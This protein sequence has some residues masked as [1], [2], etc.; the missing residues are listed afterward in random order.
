MEWVVLGYTLSLAVFIPTSGWLGDRFG[1]E[2]HLPVRADPRSRSVRS[3]VAWRSPST[4]LIAFRVV[5]GIGG[6]MLTPVG[7]AM[8]FRA[9]PPAERAKASTVVMVPTLIA[10]AMGPVLGGFI[11]TNFD[12]RWIFLVN[13]PIAMGAWWFGWR[14]LR[15][16]KESTAGRFDASG[17]VLSAAA[18]ASDR[19]TRSAKDHVPAGLSD[20]VL[21]TGGMGALF[22]V[23]TVFVELK[24]RYP[25]LELRLLGNRMFRQ[26]NTV[27]F[28]SIASFLGVTF[29][30][31]LYLQ[32]IRGMDPLESGLTT[33]PQAIGVMASSFIAGSLYARI[34][35]RRLMTGGF[36]S[37]GL[38]IA[39]Y[40]GLDRGHEPVADP[41]LDVVAWLL[42]GLR[43]R[44]DAGCQLR[45]DPTGDERPRL[46]AVL[47]PTTGGR[48]VRCGHPGQRAGGPHVAQP[49]GAGGRAR[50]SPH[51]HSLGLR[52]GDAVRHRGGRGSVVHPR[53]GRQGDD[54]R[55][56]ADPSTSAL[57][58]I[59]CGQEGERM[60]DCRMTTMVGRM[61]RWGARSISG[62]VAL[63]ALWPAACSSQPG[64][65]ATES[66]AR[67]TVG[68][69]WR[70]DPTDPRLFT[71]DNGLVVYLRENNRPGGS[72]EMRLVIDAGSAMEGPD[73]AG[74]AHFL[75][76]MLFNGTEQFPG[77]ELIDVLRGFGM[78]FGADV[79]AYTS[80]DETVYELTVPV[81]ESDNLATGCRRPGG[82]AR[83][84]PLMADEDEV[85]GRTW[86]GAR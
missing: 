33:F 58:A 16:H 46:F 13:V 29:V 71:L 60:V 36:L 4:Q 55:R 35:P 9:F 34:G 74:V 85:D 80:Y 51:R 5:Q 47:H 72:A 38:T 77:N 7:I 30:M 20:V 61:R 56:A 14:Y 84:R 57:G 76:H 1:T 45:D 65:T 6:G 52:V 39:F 3:S 37:A 63:V 11:T 31:P 70:P 44:A 82:M 68:G 8:L 12:W 43:L 28:F 59:V 23:A 67:G 64:V 62:V 50:P 15:E 79:N 83:R 17:F 66:A 42:H 2:A 24:V 48:V 19:C 73:Q 10:P 40:V 54:G 25:M 41:W 81:D 69:R 22:A 26:C 27:S 49:G 78:E 18:L 53:R 21:W 32:L 75:E 86:C